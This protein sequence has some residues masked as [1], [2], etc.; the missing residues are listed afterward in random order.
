MFGLQL[1]PFFSITLSKIS[2]CLSMFGLQL[3]SRIRSIQETKRY[4][5]S[6]FG[7]QL[8]RDCP[9]LHRGTRLLLKHVRVATIPFGRCERCRPRYCLSMFGLQP[10]DFQGKNQAMLD[11]NVQKRSDFV[12]NVRCCKN[13]GRLT[14]KVVI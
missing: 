6:M 8:H 11:L 12:V 4:C 1:F 5:L 13:T 9:R 2:Y 7:L 3:M 14:T 10:P